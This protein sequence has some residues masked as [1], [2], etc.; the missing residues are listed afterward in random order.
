MVTFS[1]LAGPATLHTSHANAPTV[2]EQLKSAT[3]APGGTYI[4]A[5]FRCPAGQT[6]AF[7]MQSAGTTMLNLFQDY[8][9]PGMEVTG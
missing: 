7:L 6:I 3:L 2:A 9:L 8:N 4:L 1:R 5:N